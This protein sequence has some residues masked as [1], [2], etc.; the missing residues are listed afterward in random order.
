MGLEI[1]EKGQLGLHEVGD[2]AQCS[3]ARFHSQVSSELWDWIRSPRKEL[4]IEV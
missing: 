4:R 1:P 3:D 2:G